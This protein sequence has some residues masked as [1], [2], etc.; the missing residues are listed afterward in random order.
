MPNQKF[1]YYNYQ[2][3][4]LIRENDVDEALPFIDKLKMKEVASSRTRTAYTYSPEF[5]E[6]LSGYTYLDDYVQD[7]HKD[8]VH[9]VKIKNPENEEAP[10]W[11]DF[12]RI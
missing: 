7:G 11:C 10:S 1:Y 4:I 5:P 9:L 12:D 8:K 3:V 2:K 6:S